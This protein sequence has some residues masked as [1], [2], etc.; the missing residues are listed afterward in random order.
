MPRYFCEFC[1]KMLLN[2][3]LRSRRMHCGG[4]KHGLMRKAYYM[5][6]FEKEDIAAEMASILRD[7][8]T[9]GEKVECEGSKSTSY[10]PFPPGD[11]YLN[12]ALPEE[13]KGFRLPSG[14][15]FRDKKNFP[16]NITEAIERYT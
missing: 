14:F 12:L 2:D 6:M 5:E 15:D 16:E 10:P 1:N 11:F 3:R 4:A 8:K 13:P 7:I 9:A